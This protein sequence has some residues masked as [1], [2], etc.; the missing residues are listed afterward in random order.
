MNCITD[1]NCRTGVLCVNVYVKGWAVETTFFFL[2]NWTFQDCIMIQH[3]GLQVPMRCTSVTLTMYVI[4]GCRFGWMT[5][6]NGIHQTHLNLKAWLA[7]LKVVL[8]HTRQSHWWAANL[9]LMAPAFTKQE[10]LCKKNYAQHCSN[11]SKPAQ[12]GLRGG[13]H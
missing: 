13:R 2:F 11:R 6:L 12:Y 5:L 9:K 1:T 4:T 3:A 7:S 10:S 8:A